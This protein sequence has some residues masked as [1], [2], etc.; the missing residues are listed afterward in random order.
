VPQFTIGAVYNVAEGERVQDWYLSSD[1]MAGM[2]QMPP[3]ST[4]HADWYGAWDG[5][6]LRTWTANC[7]DRVLSCSAGELGDGTI[8]RR[9]A[10]YGLVANPRLV[11]IPPRPAAAAGGM[12]DMR[13]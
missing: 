13:K 1:R 7:I 5:T 10:G 12:S 9:R 6:T 8:M 11:P 4:F 3:G 2:P